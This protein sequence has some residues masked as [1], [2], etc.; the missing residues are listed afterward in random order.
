MI[1]RCREK[2]EDVQTGS[3]GALMDVSLVNDG[4]FT[5]ILDSKELFDA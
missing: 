3:F 1:S 5:V 2:T 4:P